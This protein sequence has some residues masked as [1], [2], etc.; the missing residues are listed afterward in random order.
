MMKKKLAKGDPKEEIFTVLS[1][2]GK[3]GKS[4]GE[5]MSSFSQMGGTT[6]PM[7]YSE[8]FYSAGGKP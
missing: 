2:F 7:S 6:T 1:K 5:F 4:S 8:A 3:K